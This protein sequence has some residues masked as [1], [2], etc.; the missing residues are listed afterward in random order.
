ML[1]TAKNLS[2]TIYLWEFLGIFKRI[3][4]RQMECFLFS[5]LRNSFKVQGGVGVCVFGN[6]G[7]AWV[8]R[9]L[10]SIGP[11]LPLRFQLLR[12]PQC[13]VPVY[14]VWQT[15][16]FSPFFRHISP[17]FVSPCLLPPNY[18]LLH[19]GFP[20]GSDG[21]E[22]ACNSGDRGSIPGLGRF[23]GEGSGNPL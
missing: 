11:Q 22:S 12:P 6:G 9:M 2:A 15:L 18:I 21:K 20:G 7:D 19:W 8:R 3:S 10:F 13:H 14:S 4:G 16:Q 17:F 1:V 5:L 23:S